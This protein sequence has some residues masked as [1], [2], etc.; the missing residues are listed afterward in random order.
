MAA[1]FAIISLFDRL[2]PVVGI[3]PDDLRFTKP[4]PLFRDDDT[5]IHE[6]CMNKARNDSLV[7]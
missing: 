4:N 5:N 2:E 1:G 3:E 7:G 6:T